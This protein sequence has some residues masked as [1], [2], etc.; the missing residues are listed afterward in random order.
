MKSHTSALAALAACLGL[1]LASPVRADVP[2][3]APEAPSRAP[4]TA[5]GA[6]ET[7]VPRVPGPPPLERG[8][9]PRT[10][11]RHPNGREWVVA[12]FYGEKRV[13]DEQFSPEGHKTADVLIDGHKA[14]TW[15]YHLTGAV[16][17]IYVQIDGKKEGQE[18]RYDAE[19]H[20][21]A[22]IAYQ[23]GQRHGRQ[24]EFLP[25]FDAAGQCDRRAVVD[26]KQGEPQ[27]PMLTYYAT[28]EREGAV[29][30]VNERK[31]GI[32][33]QYFK[34]GKK[35]AEVPY[36]FGNEQGLAKFYAEDGR[37]QV[38]V[39]YVNGKAHGQE[40]RYFP[41]GQAQMTLP[42][43]EGE[44]VGTGLAYDEQ[45]R[46][47]AEMTWR[48]GKQD[49]PEKRF[50]EAGRLVTIVDFQNGAACCRIVTYY[51][52]TG[53]Q[54][55]QRTWKFGATEG[56]ETRWQDAPDEI[57]QMKARVTFDAKTG[58]G[59]LDGPAELFDAEG[60]LWSR[61]TFKADMRD[62]T[63]TRFSACA[64]N[65]CG[66]GTKRAEFQWKNDQFTGD[67]V[68][69]WP[70]GK[71]QSVFPFEGGAGTGTERR[72]DDKGLLRM[73]IPLVKG[74]KQGV[75][76]VYGDKPAHGRGNLVA[77]LTYA[78]DVQTG[79]EVRFD[80]RGKPT[81]R[82]T[83]DHGQLVA[84]TDAKGKPV[85]LSQ[86][87]GPEELAQVAP[88]D[89][90]KAAEAQRVIDLA[91]RD[92]ALRSGAGRVGRG[93]A[94][95]KSAEVARV[96]APTKKGRNYE[97]YFADGKVQSRFPVDGNGLEV[98]YHAGGKERLVV[99]LRDGKRDGTA[100]IFDETG[101]LWATI[102]YQEGKKNGIEV[103]YARTGEKVGE[104][105][106][107]EDKPVGIA[108]TWYPDG[109]KQSEFHHN[110]QGPGTEVHY[111]RSGEVRLHVPLLNGKRQGV[112][113]IYTE[114]G[115]R[116]AEL[117]FERG[118]EHGTEV[119]FD[120]DGRKIRE[121]VWDHGKVVKDSERVQA[122]R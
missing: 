91:R 5:V 14:R 113:S 107:K 61:L 16:A 55:S 96:G 19:G 23:G 121:I 13:R 56:E 20:P 117:P 88:P 63:E 17:A 59:R 102:L 100:R 34:D 57:V 25:P 9:M 31:H 115:L 52:T 35:K 38:T 83:W 94:G 110:G 116:W 3:R 33:V 45:G 51:P 21:A 29:P 98:Q 50:D 73:E 11:T 85:P 39:P 47:R 10:M 15:L 87:M 122:D 84:A 72:W 28:G 43:Q 6:P 105:P 103:H 36:A 62:G 92:K 54:R 49:G 7:P 119:R 27:G 120:R 65:A 77:T 76:R 67:A 81:W 1:A 108:R 70:N 8:L 44:R 60:K 89:V 26:W 112:A 75:A 30:V 74:K 48:D 4:E 41:N 90:A 12:H 106:Y 97:T 40:T 37:L 82:Y 95:A 78:D 18:L 71:K 79:E 66:E 64:G 46:K 69:F 53:R 2:G 111:H 99:P 80:G 42:W 109:A 22:I 24:I 101:A 104:Y 32:E 93:G 58:E 114:A 86:L 118:V 68:T